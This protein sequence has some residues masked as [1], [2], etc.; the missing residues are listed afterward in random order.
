[1]REDREPL[2]SPDRIAFTLWNASVS[3]SDLLVVRRIGRLVELF[4]RGG[5]VQMRSI[6]LRKRD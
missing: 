1:L 6:I 4:L 5:N 3:E 2:M